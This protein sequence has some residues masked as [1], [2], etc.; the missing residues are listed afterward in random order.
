MVT[1]PQVNLS[2]QS[3]KEGEQETVNCSAQN[4][5]QDKG[6]IIAIKEGDPDRL[7]SYINACVDVNQQDENG[8]GTVM[9]ASG[10]NDEDIAHT[11]VQALISAGADVNQETKEGFT[12]L[13]TAS[14]LGHIAVVNTLISAEAEVNEQSDEFPYSTALLLAI[15]FDDRRRCLYNGSSL[16]LCWS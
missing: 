8:W 5:N 3:E 7:N 1:N 12:P 9:W 11:M 14:E 10:F 16:N 2:S 6:I 4:E 13:M 15:A